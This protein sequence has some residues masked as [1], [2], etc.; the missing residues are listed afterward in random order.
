[1]N[2]A[3]FFSVQSASRKGLKHIV[4]RL[5]T[6]EWRCDCERFVLGRKVCSHIE[7]ARLLFNDHIMPSVNLQVRRQVFIPRSQPSGKTPAVMPGHEGRG[8]IS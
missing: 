4:R 1:M 7:Q 8:F 3:N 2:N 6:G 5:A